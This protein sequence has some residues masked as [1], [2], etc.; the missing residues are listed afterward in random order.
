[1]KKIAFIHDIFPAGGAERVT[2]DIVKYLHENRLD[3]KCYVYVYRF[4]E[5]L[6]PE[7]LKGILTIK[8]ISS[9]WRERNEQVEAYVLEDGI[10]LLIQVVQPLEGIKG[11]CERTGCKAIFANHGEPFWQRY[12]IIRKRRRRLINR[13]LWHLGARRKYVKK[14]RA[15]E[16]AVSRTLQHYTNCDA[17]TVLCE[18]YKLETCKAFGIRPDESKIH[19]IENAERIVNN[20]TYDKEKIILYCGRLENVSKRI[21]RLLRIWGRIQN[22]LPDYR[23]LIV[24]DGMHRKDIEAQV[25]KEKLQ[26]VELFGAQSNVEQFYRKASIVCLTSQTEGW[27]LCLTEAQA[28]GCIPIAFGCSDGVKEILS[29]SGVNGFIVSP[30]NEK[31]YADTLVKI[32]QMSVQEQMVIRHNAVS[33][34]S[35]FTL[36]TIMPKWVNL[37]DSLINGK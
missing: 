31:E 19:V 10:D 5:E 30:F 34:R 27:G 23:L 6:F 14:G 36:E 3:Y 24:G 25:K 15:R 16:I 32:T 13:V 7:E 20:V 29:P 11:I 21:D 1:M 26:R 2:L 33:K 9:D 12:S 18:G 17:Y 22:Q 8:P 4:V 35:Q 28:H 37:F